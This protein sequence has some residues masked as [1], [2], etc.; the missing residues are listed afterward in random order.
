MALALSSSRLDPLAIFCRQKK[1]RKLI[2]QI[3]ISGANPTT[4]NAKNSKR[5]E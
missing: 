3:K 4:Q 5:H 1:E 2:L